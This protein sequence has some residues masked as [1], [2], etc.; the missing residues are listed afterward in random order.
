[1][2]ETNLLRWIATINAVLTNIKSFFELT[3]TEKLDREERKY[4]RRYARGRMDEET[5][6]Q[7]LESIERRRKLITS[8]N[9]RPS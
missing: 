4:R 8:G 7:L 5:F 1:M 9:A 2:P 6:S 3:P